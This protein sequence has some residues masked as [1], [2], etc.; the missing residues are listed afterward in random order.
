M[1]I[2]RKM[3]LACVAAGFFVVIVPPPPRFLGF[4]VIENLGYPVVGEGYFYSLGQK[5][6]VYFAPLPSVTFFMR[7]I[8]YSVKP[9]E[10]Q[11]Y[12]HFVDSS[13]DLMQLL[14]L[15]NL[16]SSSFHSS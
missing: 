14:F 16:W 11:S 15:K 2:S 6:S 10:N 13:F 1:L 4:L 12:I 5:A 7:L 3:L 8:G 9:S